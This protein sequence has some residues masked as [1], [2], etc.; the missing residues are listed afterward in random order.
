MSGNSALGYLP[1]LRVREEGWVC[2]GAPDP[3]P[4]PHVGEAGNHT[5]QHKDVAPVANTDMVAPA[6]SL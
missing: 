6:E 3:L 5:H 2:P 4:M 1:H